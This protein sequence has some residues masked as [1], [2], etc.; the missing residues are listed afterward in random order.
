MPFQDA[1][2]GDIR[3]AELPGVFYPSL[4]I[5]KRVSLPAAYAIQRTHATLIEV[6]HRHGFASQNGTDTTG[7]VECYRLRTVLRPGRR[8][9]LAVE[10]VIEHRSL[11]DYVLFPVT[12]DGGR[13][14]AVHLEPKSKYGL[15]R[16]AELNLTPRPDWDF[17]VLR[18][19]R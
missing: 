18:I 15:H 10:T 5:T 6:L 9:R 13:A 1:R 14:L 12:P 4:K 3:E 11:A 17:P 19:P 8:A 16:Y 7:A 2:S